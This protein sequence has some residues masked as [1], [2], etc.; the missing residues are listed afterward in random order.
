MMHTT[1]EVLV[2]IEEEDGSNLDLNGR[3][4]VLDTVIEEPIPMRE[5]ALLQETYQGGAGMNH[6]DIDGL[7]V[8]FDAIPRK[9]YLI[10]TKD[11]YEYDP[12]KNT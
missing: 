2:E 3:K 6:G 5:V 1:V 9:R 10:I 12:E 11:D 8:V 4:V 7:T